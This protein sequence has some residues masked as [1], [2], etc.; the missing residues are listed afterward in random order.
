[1][2]SGDDILEKIQKAKQEYY[3]E[4]QK[5][6]FFKNKQKLECASQVVQQID[7]NMVCEKILSYEKNCLFFNYPLFKLIANPQ[8]YNELSNRAFFV[9][10]EILKNYSSYDINLDLQGITMSAIE[11][12]KGF[13]TLISSEGI[14]NGKNYLKS[15]NRIYV[16]NPPSFV[17]AGCKI[18]LP[19]LD[20][21]ITGRIVIIPK[22]I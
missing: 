3:S 8:I 11:R 16:H 19:I 6:M 18:I 15:L 10:G 7:I 9:T 1:M 4:N 22:P 12:Y 14:K 20:P 13:I 5:N 17:E 21:I 2:D